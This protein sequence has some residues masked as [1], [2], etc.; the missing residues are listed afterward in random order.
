MWPYPK[1]DTFS[2]SSGALLILPSMPVKT[3]NAQSFSPKKYPPLS[4]WFDSPLHTDD[5]KGRVGE[6]GRWKT[7]VGDSP[8]TRGF[9]SYK[10]C[11]LH[12]QQSCWRKENT[13]EETKQSVGWAVGD[14][15]Q[16]CKVP[17]RR[18]CPMDGRNLAWAG[19]AKRSSF[20]VWAT[21]LFGGGGGGGGTSVEHSSSCR[22]LVYFSF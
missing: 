19:R 10:K 13:S 1:R 20:L 15:A 5:A 7:Y 11:I 17:G 12:T 6:S 3:Y 21:C 22:V 16:L 8:H 14:T 2:S 9:S 18:S 4:L